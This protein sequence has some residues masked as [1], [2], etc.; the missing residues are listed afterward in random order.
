[1]AQFDL[2]ALG[3]TLVLDAQSDLL[4]GFATRMVV[5]LLPVDFAPRPAERLNPVFTIG[6]ARYVLMPQMMASVPV[7][8]LRNRRGSLA[9][10]HF[11]IKPAIDMLFDG[12]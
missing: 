9:H 10:E 2:Y 1:M 8:E 6:D 3:G 7:S 5:P 4:D 12:V 11:V